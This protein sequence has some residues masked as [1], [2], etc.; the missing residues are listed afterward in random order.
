MPG[1]GQLFA[2]ADRVLARSGPAVLATGLAHPRHR[3][4]ADRR[5]GYRACAVAVP[6]LL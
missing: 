2:A 6:R 5:H 3:H 4:H 1:C